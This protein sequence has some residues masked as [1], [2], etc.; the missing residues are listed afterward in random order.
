MLRKNLG[1]GV[2]V[3]GF[4]AL[5]VGSD[6]ASAQE[7]KHGGR[8][9][10]GIS[11][12][13][14]IV[15]VEELFGY[16]VEDA[17][18]VQKEAYR[19]AVGDWKYGARVWAEVMK[20]NRY[21]VP[22][23][24][25]PKLK[26][27]EN[28]TGKSD[29]ERGE[30][31]KKHLAKLESWNVC[32]VKDISGNSAARPIRKDYMLRAKIVEMTVYANAAIAWAE[33]QAGAADDNAKAPQVPAVKVVEEKLKSA[34][35]AQKVVGK[36]NAKLAK[37]REKKGIPAPNPNP[38]SIVKAEQTQW[39]GLA[40]IYHGANWGG[41]E[42]YVTAI[43][44]ADY[45]A[46]GCAEWQINACTKRG[47]DAYVFLWGHEAPTSPPKHRYDDKVLCYYL[48]DRVPPSRWGAW[49]HMEAQAYAGDPHHPTLFS[50]SPRAWGGIEVYFPTVRGRAI[51]YYHYH[52]DG[53]RKPH[54]HF[55]YLELYRQ[56]SAKN[57]YAPIVR[58][59]ESRAEDMRKTSQTV[60]TSLAYGVRGLVYGGG[61]FDGNKRD[62]R[63]VPTQNAY[64]KA[65]A[66]INKA[67]KAFSPVF[68][69]AKN[70]DVFQTK[71]LPAFTKEA[72]K[73]HWVRPA[74]AE[75]VLGV[76]ADRYNHYLLLANRDAFKAHKAT[77]HFTEKGLKV[78][79]MNKGSRKWE[80]LALK[81]EGDGRFSV[82]ISM[83]AAGGEL[84]RVI[85]HYASPTISGPDQFI[86]KAKVRITCGNLGGTIRYTL[87]GTAPTKKSAVYEKPVEIDKTSTVRAIFVHS[88]GRASSSTR[89]TF[90][91]VEPRKADGKTLGPGVAYEYYE[92][93]WSKLPSFD[94]LK[95]VARG[96]C[97]KVSLKP[98]RRE[99]NYA[100]RFTGYIEI[101]KGGSYTFTLGSDDGSRLI[102]D[103]KT[104][105]DIDGV[106]GVIT[107][108]KA[109]ELKPGMHK[110]NV[111]FFQGGGGAGL[112]LQ[113]AGPEI[114]QGPPSFWCEQ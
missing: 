7:P 43:K 15:M 55:V 75:V 90:T 84:L 11:R 40:T 98:S 4:L 102:I 30:A 91:K 44:E 113:Y 45:I 49:A 54:Y 17:K 107:R 83:E 68:K 48:G 95:P 38:S 33:T 77:L 10:Y 111:L 103:G 46:S 47:L 104:V 41:D 105:L 25:K 34:A 50:M 88:S 36:V 63:G 5:V 27:L 101:K 19:E 97:E 28:L 100:L 96:V 35:E 94:K 82:T 37:A 67:I 110:V 69:R 74:G 66:K 32:V 58:L 53:N 12:P 114:K 16:E 29:K 1:I 39:P 61:W 108:N 52:W 89:A 6:A 21:P 70:I 3:L 8:Y 112:Q 2:A 76:F 18:A 13:N 109:V 51:S 106:H 86:R 79:K 59:V 81:K 42:T 56:H 20:N 92:G 9:L 57:G 62:E 24:V 22:K 87:N 72:P 31:R 73:D 99:S 14:G 64:G 85:G 78:S 71:P 23:P 80:D 26:K 65:A 93:S 60:F